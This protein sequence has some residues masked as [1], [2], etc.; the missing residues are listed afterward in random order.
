MTKWLKGKLYQPLGSD[1]SLETFCR[2]ELEQ[3]RWKEGLDSVSTRNTGGKKISRGLTLWLIGRLNCTTVSGSPLRGYTRSLSRRRRTS[4]DEKLWRQKQP[5]WKEQLKILS[6]K[7]TCVLKILS[8]VAIKSSRT[9]QLPKNETRRQLAIQ[10]VMCPAC[11]SLSK[12]PFTVHLWLGSFLWNFTYNS[13][14]LLFYN[15]LHFK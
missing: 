3:I 2:K 8:L 13:E 5:H 14:K 11:S 7:I 1:W 4:R 15:C 6:L 9:E 12:Y 10:L